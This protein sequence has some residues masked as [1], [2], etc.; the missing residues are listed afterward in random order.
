M[1]DLINNGWIDGKMYELITDILLS[2]VK[3]KGN[4]LTC[5]NVDDVPTLW[6]YVPSCDH[7]WIKEQIDVSMCADRRYCFCVKV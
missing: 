6:R 2:V 7:V 3:Y 5:G 1:Y 4:I